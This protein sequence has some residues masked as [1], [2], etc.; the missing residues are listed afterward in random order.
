M[1]AFTPLDEFGFHHALTDTRS[2]ALVIF[3]SAG[4]GSSRTWKRLLA[5]YRTQHPDF[6]LFE[7]D[8]GHVQALACEFNVFHLLSLFLYRD[9]HFHSALHFKAHPEKLRAAIEAMLVIPAQ[10]AP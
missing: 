2:I 1:G 7:V 9:G 4:C 6:A 5:A 8:A 3:T 10:E